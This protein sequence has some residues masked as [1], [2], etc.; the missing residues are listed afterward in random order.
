MFRVLIQIS[1][2]TFDFADPHLEKLVALTPQD[3]KWMDEIVKVVDMT[4]DLPEHTS[5]V[6]FAA[7][8]TQVPR[9]RRRSPSPI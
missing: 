6:P 5:Y 3:R 4:I 8:L 9:E 7:S 2:N 1:Q